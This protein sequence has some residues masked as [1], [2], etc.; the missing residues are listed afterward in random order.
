MKSLLFFSN[1]FGY[2]PTATMMAVLRHFIQLKNVKIIV[3]AQGLCAEILDNTSN[4]H[5]VNIDQRNIAEIQKLIQQHENPYI[6][7]SLNRFAILAAYELGIPS[8]FI[9]TLTYL[10]NQIPNDYLKSNMYYC[11]DFPTVKQKTS[12]HNNAVVTP[13]IIDTKLNFSA[14]TKEREGVIVQLGGLKSPLSNLPPIDYLDL[15][16][17]ILNNTKHNITVAGGRDGLA[18]LQN[19]TSAKNI[20]FETLT[21]NEFLQKLSKSKLCISTPGLNTTIE[22]IFVKTPISF[23]MPTNLSQWVNHNIFKQCEANGIDITWED[24]IEETLNIEGLPEYDAIIRINKIAQ[25]IK[26]NTSAMNKLKE[27]FEQTISS[28]P[29]TNRQYNMLLKYGINGAE[30]IF[31]DICKKWELN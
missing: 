22:S 18:Y 20:T 17:S 13:L 1:P 23:I 6:V 15:I 27:M 12:G 29:D 28:I 19:Q 21:K 3:V 24:L 30:F 25:R 9:D 31:M 5:I 8:C 4:V 16:A 11:S 7:S 14:N 2:G 26:N 10:W